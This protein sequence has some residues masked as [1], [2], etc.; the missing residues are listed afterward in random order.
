MN[1]AAVQFVR[2]NY[3]EITFW[4]IVAALVVFV[5]GATTKP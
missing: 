1:T 2:K 3:K 4:L 5:W